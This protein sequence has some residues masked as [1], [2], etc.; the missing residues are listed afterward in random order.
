[1]F[2][3]FILF[4]INYLINLSDNLF[5]MFAPNLNWPNHYLMKVLLCLNKH[6]F[7][8]S[9]RF[10]IIGCSKASRWLQLHKNAHREALICENWTYF[11]DLD[12]TLYPLSTGFNLACRRNIEGSTIQ[13]QPWLW[14]IDVNTATGYSYVRLVTPS[15]F[16]FRVHVATL[17]HR[18]KWSTQDVFGIVP[19]TRDNNGRSK[20]N[21]SGSRF[22]LLLLLLLLFFQ[23]KLKVSVSNFRL[24]VMNLTMMSFMLLSTEN[25]LTKSWSLIQY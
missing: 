8:L 7:E 9:T 4:I 15:N 14:Y 10:L 6:L 1:M 3:Y 13:S 2:F 19:G 16:D 25:Y 5:D 11:A 17:A 20:G 12:D 24:L 21:V 23:D 22:L 18:W